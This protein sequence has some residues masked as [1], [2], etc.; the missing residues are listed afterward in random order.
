MI[1]IAVRI[2]GIL[3]TLCTEYCLNNSFFRLKRHHC[4]FHSHMSRWQLYRAFNLFA[5]FFFRSCLR[6]NLMFYVVS[7]WLWN[8]TAFYLIFSRLINQQKNTQQNGNFFSFSM[9]NKMWL[10]FT[11]WRKKNRL[12]YECEATNKGHVLYKKCIIFVAF[13]VN[14]RN[15]NTR[16]FHVWNSMC[17]IKEPNRYYFLAFEESKRFLSQRFSLRGFE[18]GAQRQNGFWF[19]CGSFTISDLLLSV[20][21]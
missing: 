19:P 12:K 13:H 6:V 4:N 16:M 9:V 11:Y 17:H 3:R 14:C 10:M 18:T 8:M 7:A 21:K 15:R 2:S 1:Q 5:L 20:C